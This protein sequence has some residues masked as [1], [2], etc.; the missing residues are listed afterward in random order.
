MEIQEQLRAKA[1]ELIDSG[2]VKMVIGYEAGSTPFKC[3]PLFAETPED[4]QKL[5]WNPACVNNL[6]V[7]LP[8][9][10]KEGKIALVAKPCDVKSIVELIKENQVK[11]EDIVILA[12]GCPG[13]IDENGM[14][15]PRSVNSVD[16]RDGGVVVV[17]GSGEAVLPKEKSFLAKCLACEL[18]DPEMANFQIGKSPERTPQADG[19]ITLEEYEKLPPEERRA[20]WTKQFEKCIRC[21]ACRSAC[22]GCYCK[23]CFVDKPSQLWASKTTGPSANWFFHM[24]RAMHIAGRCIQCGECERACPMGIPLSL[25]GKELDGLVE[26]MFDSAPG[27]DPDA[28]PVFGCF[29]A[30]DPDPCP[31]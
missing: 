11:R 14:G 10:V 1:R 30:K 5:V 15:D 29:D 26:E 27:E 8:Q 24:C 13:V 25:L 12:V 19:R 22:P 17:R 16:W 28:L 9:M 18:A 3:T 4:T 2:Q 23:E 31:E 20:F 21:Y 6:A 7:Y